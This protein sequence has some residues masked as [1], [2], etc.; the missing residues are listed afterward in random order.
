MLMRSCIR[1]GFGREIRDFVMRLELRPR[2]VVDLAEIRDYLL[3]HAGE[4]AAER[5][6]Q[7]LVQRFKMLLRRPILGIASSHPGIRILSP[8]KYPYRIYF[9]VVDQSVVILHVRHTARDQP[10]LE[11]L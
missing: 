2:A 6:R 4:H 5:I 11:D 7:H 3:Q 1:P 8:S 9:A 10:K